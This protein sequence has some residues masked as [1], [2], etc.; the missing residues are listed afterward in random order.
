MSWG[1]TVS[2]VSLFLL[3]SM[4]YTVPLTPSMPPFGSTLSIAGVSA[5]AVLMAN[6]P[7]ATTNTIANARFMKTLLLEWDKDTQSN[8]IIAELLVRVGVSAGQKRWARKG[9]PN[10]SLT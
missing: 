1:W 8:A 5:G 2:L 9:G 10:L 3:P 4:T 7:T 6:S